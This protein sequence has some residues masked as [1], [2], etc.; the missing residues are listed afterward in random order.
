M[1]SA[2][3]TRTGGGEKFLSF[4]S[5]ELI[6]HID[7]LYRTAPYRIFM[8]HSLGGLTVINAFLHHTA[9]FNAYVATDPSMSWDNKKLLLQAKDALKENK[10]TGRSLFLAIADN[11]PPGQDTVTLWS[12]T[13]GLFNRHMQSIFTLRNTILT[14]YPRSI[15]PA[16]VPFTGQPPIP[17]KAADYMGAQP[18]R[19][20]WKYYP[21][22][23]HGTL[24]L[25][26]EYD[27]FRFVFN[28]YSL[29]FP[30]PEFFQPAWTQDTLLATHYKVISRHMGYK[31][32]PPETVVNNIGYQLMNSRQFDRAAY[33]FYL[34]IEN[35]PESFN[36]YDSMGDL[37]AAR[38]DKDTAIKCFEKVLTLRENPETRQKLE[39]LRR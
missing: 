10:F 38:G 16:F 39:N 13:S 35:Y 24:P 29:N 30:F 21:D 12:D 17:E 5:N 2:S 15:P 14:A 3:A 18:F 31:I 34:N 19:F 4:I 25:P 33:F 1:D 6:P 8:G 22:C 20:S 7:S 37:M 9:M 27:A 32:P 36:V 23:D 11:I 28:Y 26:A